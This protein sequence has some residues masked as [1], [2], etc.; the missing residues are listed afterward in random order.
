MSREAAAEALERLGAKVTSSLSRKTSALIVGADPGSKL[1][2]AR[3][4]GVAELD[5]QQLLDLI[6]K[7]GS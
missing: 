6:M 4:L 1:E 3:G 5:E 7:P 2:K